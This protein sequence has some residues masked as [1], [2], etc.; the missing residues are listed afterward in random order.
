MADHIYIEPLTPS[1]LTRIIRKER[2]DGLLA[3]L[4]GQTALNLAM[5]LEEEGI[6]RQYGVQLLGTNKD[7][8]RKAEDREAFR[9]LMQASCNCPFRKA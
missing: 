6:L 1:F 7:T 8:I 9:Q 5:Q 2:P 4:G 3:T